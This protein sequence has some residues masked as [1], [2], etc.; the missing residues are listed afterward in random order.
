MQKFLPILF[1]RSTPGHSLKLRSY[2]LLFWLFLTVTGAQAQKEYAIKINPDKVYQTIDNFG[3]AGC[4]FGENIGKYW[5]EE[6]K[7]TIARLLFSKKADE[8]GNPE[9]IGLSAWRFNIG[10]GT[11]EQG[12]QSGISD[13]NKRVESFLNADGTYDW[14]K[15]EGYRWLTKKARDYGVERL[16]AFSNSPPVHF[17]RNGLG[18]KTEKDK[19]TN[20]K[21][22][23][24]A[25]FADFLATVVAHFKDEGIQFD[26]LS[27]VNEPQWDWYGEVGKAKQEGSPWTNEDIYR[28]TK[29]LN[30]RLLEKGLGTEILL[31]EAAQLNFLYE[32]EGVGRNQIREL[33]SPE[34][35]LYVGGLERVPSLIVGHSY[36][37]DTPDERMLN[38]REQVKNTAREYE[39]DFWQSEYSMLADGFREGTDSKRTA[40][41]CALFLS[42]VIHFDLTLANA[43]AWQFWNAFEPGDPDFDTRYYMI[44]LDPNEDHTDGDFYPVKTLWAMGHYS[45]FVNPGMKRIETTTKLGPMASAQELMTSAYYDPISGK[46]SLVLIN[47]NNEEARVNI[48]GDQFKEHKSFRHYLTTKDPGMDLKKVAEGGSLETLI[49]PARSISTIVFEM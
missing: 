43:K 17:T 44:A 3:A 40:M 9:G 10:A 5:P 46:I 29:L 7:E 25:D 12:E 4:W 27:P 24:F 6:K 32:G 36:F 16:I 11:F 37:T 26:Y 15:Q 38:I 8:A 20:L 33:F 19:R 39:I 23:K 47:Y 13:I 41:D 2:L 30:H 14:T 28:L 22:D 18:F 21:D 49:L 45:Y 48:G 31:S 1:N 34:S 42:K 35:P